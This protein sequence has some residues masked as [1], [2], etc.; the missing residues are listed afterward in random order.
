MIQNRNRSENWNVLP[1]FNVLVIWPK[2]EDASSLPGAANCGVLKK[3]IDSAR[4]ARLFSPDTFHMRVSDAFTFRMP[5]FRN[6]L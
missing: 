3:L 5:P 1:S 2:L 6:T 4:N